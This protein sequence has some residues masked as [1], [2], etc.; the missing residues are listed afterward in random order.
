MIRISVTEADIDAGIRM[1]PESCP[2]NLAAERATDK[3][4]RTMRT[5]IVIGDSAVRYALP[6]EAREFIFRF[7]MGHDV[8]PF[9]FVIG[10]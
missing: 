3:G 5:L 6:A 9:E 2:I 10:E 4:C 7:D 8:E 1:H